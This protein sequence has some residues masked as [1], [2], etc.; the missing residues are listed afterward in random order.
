[1]RFVQNGMRPKLSILLSGNGVVKKLTP[2]HRLHFV[3]DLLVPD[4]CLLFFHHW[5]L[6]FCLFALLVLSR[7]SPPI[8]YICSVDNAMVSWG[9]VVALARRRM[10][11]EVV[12]RAIYIHTFSFQVGSDLIWALWQISH[13]IHKCQKRTSYQRQCIT[14]THLESLEGNFTNMLL[15]IGCRF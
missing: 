14:S 12:K 10:V 3:P 8:G 15:N 4:G 5:L 9:E 7:S 1:M 2:L 11:P 13:L 6:L